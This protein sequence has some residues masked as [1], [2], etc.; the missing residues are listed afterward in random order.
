V[1]S[2]ATASGRHISPVELVL[3]VLAVAGLVAS[4][5]VHLHLAHLYAGNGGTISQGDLF[6]AQGVVALVV[7]A[8]LLVTGWRWVWLAAGVVGV[9]SLAAVLASRYTSLGAIGPF[10]NMHDASW[11][12]SPDKFGSAV[13]EAAVFVLAVMWALVARTRRGDRRPEFSRSH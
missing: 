2:T 9:A 8:L 12:P 13:A 7:A 10:P 11:Q 4:G 6:V 5:Y 3:R 1:T